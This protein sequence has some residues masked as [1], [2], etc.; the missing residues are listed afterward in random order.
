MDQIRKDKKRSAVI[1]VS[2]A[3]GMSVFLCVTTLLESQGART[4]VT[5]HMDND[6]TIIN[7]TLKKEDVQ[8]HK[9]LLTEAFLDDLRSISGT[10]GAGVCGDV[11]GRILCKMDEYP[12]RGRPRRI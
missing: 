8:E 1:M 3:A 5:N 12:L 4:I 11:D 7:D 10:L 6:M 9:D 2:L